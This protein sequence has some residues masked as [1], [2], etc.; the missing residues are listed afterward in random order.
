MLPQKSKTGLF[1]DAPIKPKNAL[2]CGGKRSATPLLLVVSGQPPIE[3][4]K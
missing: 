2:D 1:S 4:M 3:A